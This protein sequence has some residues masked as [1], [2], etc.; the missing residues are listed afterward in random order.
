M[1]T[2]LI[3]L[4]RGHVTELWVCLMWLGFSEKLQW[5]GSFHCM[6]WVF[7]DSEECFTKKCFD[8][9]LSAASCKLTGYGIHTKG[10]T[11]RHPGHRKL[12]SWPVGKRFP[13]HQIETN[14]FVI[15]GCGPAEN[16][17]GVSP[18]HVTPVWCE[19]LETKKLKSSSEIEKCICRI[20]W[21]PNFEVQVGPTSSNKFTGNGWNLQRK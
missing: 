5:F 10:D 21:I 8:Q 19:I 14:T 16:P 18:Q 3:I 12:S 9:V 17:T 15:K 7:S 6:L 1:I 4:P 13:C 2:N 20:N 11:T